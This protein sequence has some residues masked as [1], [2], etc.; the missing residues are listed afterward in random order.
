VTAASAS[1]LAVIT[2]AGPILTGGKFTVSV[3]AVD[4]FGNVDLTFKGQVT[5]A[6]GNNPTG[7]IL[8]GTLTANAAGGVATFILQISKPG[9]AYTLQATSNGLGGGA[10]APLA[11]LNQ[12]V[13]ITPPPGTVTAG[14]SFGLVVTA[15]DGL[16]NVAEDGLGN[17]V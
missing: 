1:Q 10:S 2:P 5:L 7:A 3:Q 9:Q 16:G 4:P 13:V 17:A 11:V 14:S 15:E 8:G 6:L 12:L